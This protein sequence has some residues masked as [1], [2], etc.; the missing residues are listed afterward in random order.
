VLIADCG[1]LIEGRDRGSERMF[2]R[3]TAV[4]VMSVVG[5]AAIAE[6]W[7][8]FRGPN[9]DG[10]SREPVVPLTWSA[11]DSVMWAT[12]LPGAGNSSPIVW[13]DRVFVTAALDG[14]KERSLYCFNRETG[15]LIWGRALEYEGTEPT[16][17]T[18][19]YAAATPVTDGERVY[20]WYGS[21]GMA[22][23]DMEGNELW[24][25]DGG[26]V[27]H[28]WGNGSSP[29]LFEDQ[30]IQY[31][32]PGEVSTL[33]ALNKVT[34]ALIW[35]RDIPESRNRYTTEGD[36][37]QWFGTWAT[38]IVVENEGRPELVF[39]VSYSVRGFNP[40]TG[41]ELWRCGGLSGLAYASVSVDGGMA[42]AMSGFTGPAIG[43]RLPGAG[44]GGDVTESHRL[45]GHERNEQRIGSGVAY[46][47]HLYV[48]NAN[49]V[50]QCIEMASG[51]EVWKERLTTAECWGS[52][53]LA[54]G[55]L[56]V[57]DTAGVTHVIAASTKF[58]RLAEN[59][60]GEGEQTRSTAAFS[61]GQVFIRTYEK[62]YCIGTRL[63]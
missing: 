7:P 20:V 46:R 11:T 38:P 35:R 3:F 43:L 57:T 53:V 58:E 62:L 24:Q 52:M 21:G 33:V 47:G 25:F 48:T 13:G 5:G 51:R 63:R 36:Q 22:A 41:V 10:I 17:E 32:G 27:K 28:I 23:F 26:E 50:A 45:W 2:R 37:A 8:G 44:D 9:G 40:R 34:G 16:H 54:A 56:Y 12:E 30:V 60:L 18:N 31:I 59:R 49:G 39:P 6:N 55:R 14:G 15:R 19:P 42:A 61:D 1:L 29:I 4:M